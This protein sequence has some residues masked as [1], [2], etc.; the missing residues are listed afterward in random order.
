MIERPSSNGSR[1]SPGTPSASVHVNVSPSTPFVSASWADARPP[2]GRR[3][4]RSDVVERFL[5]DRAIPRLARHD[6]R[7]QV[8]GGEQRVVVEHLLE[9]R[10]EPAVVD[11][12]AVEAAADEVVHP[13]RRHAVERLRTISIA[14]GEPRRSRNSRVDAGGNFGRPAEAAVR[15]LEG[16]RDATLGLD[17]AARR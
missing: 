15:R 6:P 10:H 9:V 3:S 4:S 12:V 7:V 14:S 1:S 17:A 11:R 16:A 8:R 13:A 5:D 2:P